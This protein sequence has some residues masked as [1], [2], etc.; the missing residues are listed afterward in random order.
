MTPVSK[1]SYPRLRPADAWF[2]ARLPC[3]RK[4]YELGSSSALDDRELAAKDR[5]DEPPLPIPDM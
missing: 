4:V 2:D 5:Y 1:S 3:D